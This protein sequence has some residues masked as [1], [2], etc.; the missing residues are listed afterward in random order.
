MGAA[1]P[2]A[3]AQRQSGWALANAAPSPALRKG[4]HRFT[5]EFRRELV[6]RVDQPG[7]QSSREYWMPRRSP[8]WLARGDEA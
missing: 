5:E 2:P 1:L 8:T 4:R 7:A 6:G 3:G